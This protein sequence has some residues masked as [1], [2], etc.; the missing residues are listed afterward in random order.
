M[1][2]ISITK[3]K[4][5]EREVA[6]KLREV[7]PEARRGLA[8]PRSGDETPDVDG[9]PFW[10]ECKVGQRIN[11]QAALS[12]ATD[13]TDGRPPLAVCK[14]DREPATATMLLSDFI[15]LVTNGN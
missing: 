10:V 6:A 5:F 14:V 12:Q 9:T 2:R 8:Q 4:N 13:A 1:A 11:V 7:Y 15:N 3:G